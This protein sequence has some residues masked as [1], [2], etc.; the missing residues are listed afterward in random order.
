[1]YCVVLNIINS[2]PFFNDTDCTLGIAVKQYLDEIASNG[3]TTQSAKQTARQKGQKSWFPQAVDFSASIDVAFNLF[4]CLEVVVQDL[5][6]DVISKE[7][8]AEWKAVKLWLQ[9]RR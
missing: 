1:M 9:E 6:I 7:M 3:S 5:P 2:L 8:K 4:D